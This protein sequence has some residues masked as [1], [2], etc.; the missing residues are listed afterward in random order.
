MFFTS[1]FDNASTS[2][3]FFIEVYPSMFAFFASSFNSATV[4]FDRSLV[5]SFF[6]STF[7]VST[8]LVSTFLVSFTSTVLPSK[9]A[10]ATKTKLVNA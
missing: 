8:F 3:A 10:F 5:S 6:V 2:S 7:L 1:Y 9:A 4:N